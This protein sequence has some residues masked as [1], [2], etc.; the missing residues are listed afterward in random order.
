MTLPLKV[1]TTQLSATDYNTHKQHLKARL[2][3]VVSYLHHTPVVSVAEYAQMTQL[4][5]REAAAEL[6]SFAHG[7]HA[8]L[9]RV[10]GKGQK[11]RYALRHGTANPHK[12]RHGYH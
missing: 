8:P 6:K 7:R 11:A 5:H 4:T 9:R 10:G 3:Q 1:A 12:L 2:G